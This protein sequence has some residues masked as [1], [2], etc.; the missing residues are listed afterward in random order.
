M[1]GRPKA[2]VQDS[3][4]LGGNVMKFEFSSKNVARVAAFA[5]AL[6]VPALASAAC[7]INAG[8]ALPYSV[9]AA[10]VTGAL[11]IVAPAG[12]PWTFHNRG[13]SW[14]QI[15]SAQSGSGSA[16]IYYRILPN[17]TG[18]ARSA[19]FGPEGV[20]GY[21]A[22]LGGRSTTVTQLSNGFTITVSQSAR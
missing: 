11:Q 10:G 12:C 5:F 9:G 8:S 2:N 13:V 15:L 19:G 4:Q 16:V 7:Q 1:N 14:I 20:Q 22:Y 17:Y 6:V 18:R 3:K 21:S